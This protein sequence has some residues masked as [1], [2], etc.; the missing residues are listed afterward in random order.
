ME[1]TDA[2]R[3]KTR[4]TIIKVAAKL[5]RAEGAEGVT[6]R[7]VATEADVQAP[8]IYRIFGD[9][10]GLLD[11]VAEHVFATYVATKARTKPSGDPV[12]DLRAG[13]DLHIEFSLANPEVFTLL[14][15][16]R[17]HASPAVAA[18]H[19][20]LRGKIHR[21]AAA[22]RLR[23]AE[24]HAV[25]LLHATGTGVLLSLIARPPAERDLA[26]ADLAFDAI[27]RAI[28]TNAPSAPAGNVTAAAV[29]LRS[30]LGSLDA[31]SPGEAALM[32]EWLQRV[33]K[34]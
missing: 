9:K 28:I 31:L 27:L 6:T 17:R 18:G 15:D 30:S 23:I 34:R 12:A 7:A 4:T 25:E 14:V 3:H 16:P 24:A 2:A 29:T 19:E 11:A 8:T 21:V 26:L 5:L 32:G 13:W 10:D 20:V 22:G 33:I 1:L